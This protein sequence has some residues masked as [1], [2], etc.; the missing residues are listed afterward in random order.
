MRRF[1]I[2]TILCLLCGSLHAQQPQR[3]RIKNFDTEKGVVTINTPDG[4]VVEANI[5]PQTIF[6]DGNNQ[7][8]AG[9]REKGVRPTQT[10]QIR[11][12]QWR[13]ALLSDNCAQAKNDHQQHGDTNTQTGV[14]LSV[15]RG[16]FHRLLVTDS[17]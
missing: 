15:E 8:I 2:A 1:L 9:A 11:G 13:G 3:G 4:S 10:R 14:R 12:R 17:P 7:D 16:E 6:H 5:A